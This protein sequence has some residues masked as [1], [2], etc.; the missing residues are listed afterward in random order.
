MV[1]AFIADVAAIEDGSPSAFISGI[2]VGQLTALLVAE[3]EDA[4][5]ME[6]LTNGAGLF[7]DAA[8][9]ASIPA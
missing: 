4:A 2:A 1:P 7:R 8:F 5:H 3:F 9:A 6:L